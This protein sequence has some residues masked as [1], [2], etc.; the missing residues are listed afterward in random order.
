MQT[1]ETHARK[2]SELVRELAREAGTRSR[3][4]L[5]FG[6]VLAMGAVLSFMAALCVVAGVFGARADLP[7]LPA[8]GIFQFKVAAMGLLACGALALLRA[9]GM[10]GARLRPWLAVLPVA[11]LLLVGVWVD[12]SGFPITGARSVSIPVCLGA[13]VLAAAPGLAILLAVLRRGIPTRLASAGAMA[14]LL[15]GALGAL[16]YTIA[17]INDGALF[18]AVWYSAAILATTLL[19]AILGPRILA[20]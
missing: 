6:W 13:I 18:V 2:T 1:T 19:G 7:G 20:W 5:P 12:G 11:L 8:S 17:C 16:A 14:G 9:A 4:R 15:S 3:T 10:P